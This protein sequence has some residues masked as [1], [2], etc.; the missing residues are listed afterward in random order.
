M[1]Q[2]GLGVNEIKTYM[3]NTRN[4]VRF[5]DTENLETDNYTFQKVNEFKYLGSCY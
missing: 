2:V 4:I 3:I 1:V 5:R